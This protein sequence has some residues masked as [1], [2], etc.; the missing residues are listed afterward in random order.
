MARRPGEEDF[1]L[2]EQFGIKAIGDRLREM[3]GNPSCDGQPS[4]SG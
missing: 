2:L 3:A 1:D 4:R